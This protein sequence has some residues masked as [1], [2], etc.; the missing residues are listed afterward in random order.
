MNP[1]YGGLMVKWLQNEI[2]QKIYKM[3]KSQ[4]S[5]LKEAV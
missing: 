1:V 4:L 2:V 5:S 3:G